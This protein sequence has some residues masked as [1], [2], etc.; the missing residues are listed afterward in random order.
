MFRQNLTMKKILF[1][2]ILLFSSLTFSEEIIHDVK[3]GKHH[4]S[5][6]VRIETIENGSDSFTAK[7]K[8]KI[9]KKFY[10]PISNRKLQGELEQK[11]PN[12]FSSL[13][14]YLSL[15]ETGSLEL[16]KATIKFIKRV[17]IGE[18]YGSFQFQIIPRNNKWKA[19]I[20][21]HPD[22]KSLGWHRSEIT[23]FAIPVLG[24]YVVNSYLRK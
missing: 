9:K 22:V 20:W 17:D 21:Y 14:G 23:I 11:L 15:E 7:L 19:T 8:Y 24:K 16:E 2:L 10:I 4:K 5:G 3:R 6:E 1:S 12:N 13:E 18:Y